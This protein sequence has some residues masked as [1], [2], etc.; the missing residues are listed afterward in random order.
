MR[1]VRSRDRRVDGEFRP[2]ARPVPRE[3]G[4]RGDL[5]VDSTTMVYVTARTRSGST[6]PKLMTWVPGGS[7]ASIT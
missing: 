3:A 5:A 7:G 4:Q 2:L 1:R 6:P